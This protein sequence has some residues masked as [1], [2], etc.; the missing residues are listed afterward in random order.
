MS[1]FILLLFL[2]YESINCCNNMEEKTNISF[3]MFYFIML[4]I[5]YILVINNKLL[6]CDK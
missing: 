4:F 6:N 3:Q 1:L 5:C 2:L